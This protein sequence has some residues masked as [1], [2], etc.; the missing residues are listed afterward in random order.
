MTL[1]AVDPG[2]SVKPSIGYALFNPD[3]VELIER[4]A[5]TWDGFFDELSLVNPARPYGFLR[6]FGFTVGEVVVE[7]FVNTPKSRG[8]QHNGTSECIGAIEILCRKTSTP[9]KRQ[10]N[11]ILPVAK[12]LAGYEQTLQHLP[13]EDSAYLH[14]IYRLVEL[15]QLQSRGL[16]STL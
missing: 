2:R 5:L 8:G 14:G 12:L 9:F 16:S 3:G 11:T 4:G 10:P 6:F 1:L 15:G 13:D 7:D